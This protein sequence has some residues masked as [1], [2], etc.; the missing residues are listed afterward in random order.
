[1]LVVGLTGG[2]ATGKSTVSGI[3]KSHNITVIDA[4]ILAREVVQPGTRGLRKIVTEFGPEILNSDGSLNRTKLGDIIFNNELKRKKLNAIIHPAVRYAMFWGVFRSW[5]RGDKICILD[6]P[7]LIEVGLWKWMG[8][9]VV[10]YCSEEVQLRRLMKRDGSKEESARAR[11]ESQ[12]PILNKLPYADYVVDNSGTI[13]ELDDQ[14]EL[15]IKR[16]NKKN[17]WFFWIASWLFPPW[18]IISAG[19]S[20]PSKKS[21][22]IPTSRLTGNTNFAVAEARTPSYQVPRTF[23]T[24][25]S[26]AE[27]P[28]FQIYTLVLR[29][30]LSNHI[31]ELLLVQRVQ[32]TVL[33]GGTLSSQGYSAIRDASAQDAKEDLQIYL[34]L[35]RVVFSQEDRVGMIGQYP[36]APIVGSIIDRI[37]PWI[38]SLSAAVLFSTG[39]GLFSYEF[40]NAESHTPSRFAFYRL[41]FFYFLCGLGTLTS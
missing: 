14:I 27:P 7:L 24:H 33:L 25:R 38:T 3:L 36:V 30:V 39:F 12:M 2:I 10:V 28:E 18:G 15:L 5:L 8:W 19:M 26:P 22:S 23:A 34:F 40:R 11:L 32:V 37:G 1:M 35:K 20:S 9:V 21:S 4:D 16:I 13:K 17:R 6:V 41:V 29:E 31:N